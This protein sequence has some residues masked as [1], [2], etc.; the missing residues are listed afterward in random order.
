MLEL[1]FHKA[2]VDEGLASKHFEGSDWSLLSRFEALLVTLRILSL[3]GRLGFADLL[4]G[5]VNSA[6]TQVL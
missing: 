4:V 2:L 1:L 3:K 5:G 6:A